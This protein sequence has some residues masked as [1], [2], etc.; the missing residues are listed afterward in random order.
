MD[1]E[2]LPDDCIV[3]ACVAK[4]DTELLP[5]GCMVDVCV[6]KMDTELLFE[7][8]LVLCAYITVCS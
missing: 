8:L 6:A 7:K 5:D 2:L 1:T 4:M 3:D